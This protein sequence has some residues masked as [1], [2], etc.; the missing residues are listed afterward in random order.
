[1]DEDS[2]LKYEFRKTRNL[3]FFSH[4]LL[5]E[6][7]WNQNNGDVPISLNDD[8]SESNIDNPKPAVF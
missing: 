2:S 8:S 3:V 5:L 4:P 6:H 1:M 7:W